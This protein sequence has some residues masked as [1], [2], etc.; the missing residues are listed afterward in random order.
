MIIEY[1]H[2]A[3]RYDTKWSFYIQATTQ[4]TLARFKLRS[5]VRVLDIGCGTGALLQQIAS[6]YPQAQLFGIDPV[7][8]MLA[9]ARQKL[10]A[11]AELKQ[12]WAEA[13]P[14]DS[15]QFDVVVSCNMF[16]YIRQPVIALQEMHRV[17][18]S[19]GQLIITDWCDDF[20]TTR[21]CDRLLRVFNRAHYKTYRQQELQQLLV[22]AGYTDVRIEGYK[23]NWMWG[24]MT[25]K[26]VKS[27][28]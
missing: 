16:H 18:R 25:A 27:S 20:W 15:E 5:N 11:K 21:L 28:A 6:N 17:L 7:A 8:E 14:F 22:D 1:S 9:I 12:A 2:L 13:L 10:P 23:I 19:N 4:E 24:L 26:T 3:D